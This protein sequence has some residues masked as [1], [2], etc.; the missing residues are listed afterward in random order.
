[1]LFQQVQVH[2]K[3]PFG[4]DEDQQS[5]LVYRS[6]MQGD[7]QVLLGCSYWTD[8]CRIDTADLW[9]AWYWTPSTPCHLPRPLYFFRAF[10]FRYSVL[11]ISKNHYSMSSFTLILIWGIIASKPS[12]IVIRSLKTFGVFLQVD[13][14]IV[15]RRNAA[16][17]VGF[18]H[19]V[20]LLASRSSRLATVGWWILVPPLM[21]QIFLDVWLTSMSSGLSLHKVA[22]QSAAWFV[23]L[24]ILCTHPRI[25]GPENGER[26]IGSKQIDNR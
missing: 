25:K 16:Y 18:D 20:S 4:I 24:A 19:R 8:S 11:F 15:G 12:A 21:L 2:F 14:L 26:H 9:K 23:K 7:E 17:I 6:W 5:T 13:W 10:P 22:I 3:D 1:M